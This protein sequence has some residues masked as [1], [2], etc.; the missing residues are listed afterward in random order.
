M[1]HNTTVFRVNTLSIVMPEPIHLFSARI[2]GHFKTATSK[3]WNGMM[4]W[5]DGM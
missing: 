1:I 2:V 4:E 5:D 3:I